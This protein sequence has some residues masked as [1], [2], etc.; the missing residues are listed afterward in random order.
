MATVMIQVTGNIQS[1]NLVCDL[2]RQKVIRLYCQQLA[3]QYEPMLFGRLMP[4]FKL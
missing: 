1:K 3:N 4:E 2:Q